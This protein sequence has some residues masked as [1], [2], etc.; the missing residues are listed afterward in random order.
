MLSEFLR[1]HRELKERIHAFRLPLSRPALAVAR[2]VYFTTPIL[3]GYFLMQWV[4][5][6]RDKNLDGNVDMNTAVRERQERLK[7]AKEVLWER[8]KKEA[9]AL[10]EGGKD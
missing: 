4:G 5:L 1:R 10:E 3:A 8:K 6:V 2:V 7:M 9:A